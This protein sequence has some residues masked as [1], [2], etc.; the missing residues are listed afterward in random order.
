MAL[1]LELEILSRLLMVCLVVVEEDLVVKLAV[2]LSKIDNQ[3]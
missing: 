2:V 1:F 3:S